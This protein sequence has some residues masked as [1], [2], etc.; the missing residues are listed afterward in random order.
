MYM[1]PTYGVFLFSF[2]VFY[3]RVWSMVMET[4]TLI[5]YAVLRSRALHTMKDIE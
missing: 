1:H 2:L 4:P 3:F 5:F